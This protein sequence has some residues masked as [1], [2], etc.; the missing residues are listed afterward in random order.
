MKTSDN[1]MINE[2]RGNIIKMFKTGEYSGLI[3]GCNCFNTM[4]SG[5]AGQI[6]REFPEASVVDSRTI[7]GDGSKLGT[8]SSTQT[9][10]GVIYNCYTQFRYGRDGERY[11]DY[12]ALYKALELV[13]NRHRFDREGL[14]VPKIGC[15]LAGG[16]WNIVKTMIQEIFSDDK[17][18]VLVDFDS[19]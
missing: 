5:I 16:N 7:R 2:T 3:H 17:N 13:R 18:V 8:Y 14:L 11:L 4:K 10:F 19:V 9:E 15:G 12:E 1:K 6:T